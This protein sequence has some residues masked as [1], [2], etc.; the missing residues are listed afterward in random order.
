MLAKVGYIVFMSLTVAIQ[1]LIALDC[2]AHASPTLEG[3]EVFPVNNV[4]NTPIDKLPVDPG[5]SA[6]IA[7]VG[8][9]DTLRPAFREGMSISY[10]APIGMPYN[11][12]SSSQAGVNVTFLYDSESD[13]GPYPIP[14]NALIEGGYKSTGDRH[15]LIIER[16]NCLLYQMSYAFPQDDGSWSAASG[17]IFNLKSNNLRPETW[18]SGDAAGL[19][20][21]PGLVRYDEVASGQI[22]HAIRVSVSQT[23]NAYIWPARHKSSTENSANYP[24]MGQRFR[25]KA[26]FDISGFSPE[27]KVILTALKKYGIIIADN[28]FSWHI[29]GVPDSRWKGDVLTTELG[30]VHGSDFEAV[31]ESSLMINADSA[32]VRR[33]PAND[34]NSDGKSDILWYNK[35]SGDTALWLINGAVVSTKTSPGAASTAWQIQGKGDFDGDGNGDILWYNTVT[36]QTAIWLT[37]IAGTLSGTAS[38]GT[39]DAAWQVKYTGDFNGDA[40]SDIVWQ[41]STTGQVAI[42][43][44][45]G[46]TVTSV[47]SLGNIDTQWQ[48]VGVGDSNGD[49]IDDVFWYNATHHQVVV[50]ILNGTI[51]SSVQSVGFSAPLWQ[52][53]G[54]GDFNGDGTADV[55]WQNSSS[56]EAAFWL[57]NNATIK[58]MASVGVAGGQWQVKGV[59]DFNGNATADVLWQ[60]SDSGEVAVWLL[61]NASIVSTGVL[62]KVDAQWTIK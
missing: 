57:L 23:R 27:A 19:P 21:L 9:N 33:A 46:S 25:L 62:G 12:V 15:L 48:M 35:T 59:G 34:F 51:I 49:G 58:D 56:G 4:W 8:A 53:R 32:Q 6:Y 30:N 11:V 5:S 14:P 22:N 44:L 37:G 3:C 54:V 50:W 36:G 29:S 31:D 42:W 1:C 20:I 24:P 38:M 55:L 17:A 40:K 13:P 10:G 2:P 7:A 16:D 41:H 43:L 52:F 61:S 18:T 60:N 28:G 47:G 26:S 39:V 45:D